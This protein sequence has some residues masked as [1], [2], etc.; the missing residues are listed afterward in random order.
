M[1]FPQKKKNHYTA[2]KHRHYTW[3]FKKT[4][5]LSRVL[6]AS[7]IILFLK[8]LR[9]ILKEASYWGKLHI[10]STGEL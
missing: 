5:Y 10:Y 9:K 3:D 2:D 4:K 1:Y 8:R 6:S 7:T